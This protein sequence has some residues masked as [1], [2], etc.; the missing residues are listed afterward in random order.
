LGVELVSFAS[1]SFAPGYVL[2]GTR[3]LDVRRALSALRDALIR[4]GVEDESLREAL[5]TA[6]DAEGLLDALPLASRAGR[7]LRKQL[8]QSLRFTLDELLAADRGKHMS[9]W[10]PAS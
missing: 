7:Q 8:P 6:H 9:W 2:T 5:A 4:A 1:A 3:M 10:H